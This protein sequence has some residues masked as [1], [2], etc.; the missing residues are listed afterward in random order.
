MGT[1]QPANP[2]ASTSSAPS[3]SRGT[4]A[5]VGRGAARGGAHSSGGPSRFYAMNG[6]Q[7]IKASLDVV[8]GILTV[9]SH[10]V[11]ALIDTGSTL[12]Y[13]IPFVAMEFGK[14]PEQLHEPF[15][16]STPIDE[17]T[18]IAPNREIDFGI[19]VMSGTQPI[20]IPPYIMAPA[21]LKELKEQLKDLLEKVKAT[22]TAEQYVQLYMKEIVRLHGTSVSII[23]DRGA[24]FTTNFWKKFLQGLGTQ[25]NHSTSFLPQTDGQAEQTI[26]TL[27]DML[28]ACTLDF[29]GSW[30]DHLPLI[31]FAYNNSFHASIQMEPFEVLYGRRCRSPIGWFEVGEVELIGPDLVHQAMEKVKIVKERLKTAQSHQKSY[32]DVRRR[33]LEFKEDNWVVGDLSTIVLVET[34]E[35]NEKLSYEEVPVVVLDRQVQKLRNKEIAS[36]LQDR[37]TS[38]PVLTLLEG[39]DGYVIYYD[40]S[41]VG[42]GCVL[43]QQSKVVAYASRQ[44]RK[45]EKNYPTHD[46]ELAAVIHALKM[47][48]H[49]LYGIHVNIYT[50]HKSLQYIFKQ[51][52]LNLH[53]MRWLELLKDYDVDILYH[54]GKVNVVADALSRRYMG[55]LSYLPPGMTDTT[56]S[57]L[58]TEVMEYHY[59]DHV[60]VHYRDTALQ[61]EKTLFEITEDGDLKY[62]ECLCVPNVA[63]LRRQVIGETHYS[64]YCIHPGATK[65]YHDIRKVYWWDG[66]KRDIVE[67][68]AQFP[69][70]QQVKIEHQKPGGLFQAIEIL[71]GNGK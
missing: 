28:R 29:K 38:I 8:I 7:T 65:M 42:L 63:G 25:I 49:Y 4:P 15:L 21:E 52:E 11:Y 47:W 18:G 57:S 59:E 5:P 56:T 16:L 1:A 71:L 24:Q 31:E 61:K 34:I 17:L 64:R 55:S 39:T 66:M 10:D 2:A 30:D 6:R 37:L 44:L 13:I 70:C 19:D 9:Q 45:H 33:D 20:S 54:S 68:V 3:L 12:S 69:N 14:E 51:K 48:R 26:Q 23:S 27:E 43:L 35:V 60:L 58:V 32:S 36:E 50:D 40:T 67:F 22:D 41:G 53:Q 46:L 62:Q